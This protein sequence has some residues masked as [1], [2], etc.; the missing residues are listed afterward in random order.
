[1]S[2]NWMHRVLRVKRHESRN[3]C[4]SN[5]LVSNFK[6]QFYHV[7]HGR[8]IVGVQQIMVHRRSLNADQDFSEWIVYVACVE[9]RLLVGPFLV[10]SSGARQFEFLLALLRKNVQMFACPIFAK[11]SSNGY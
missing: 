11:A 8:D 2:A 5:A 7:L 10:G 9:R 1:M 6:T 4:G 3:A